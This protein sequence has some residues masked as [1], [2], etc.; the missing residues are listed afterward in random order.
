MI[1]YTT[2]GTNDFD[3]AKAFYDALFA[4]MDI[5]ELWSG[6]GQAG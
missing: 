2:V 4:Q 5:G 1:S 6:D 3:K